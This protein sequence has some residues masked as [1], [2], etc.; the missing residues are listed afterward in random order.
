MYL[1]S[2]WPYQHILRHDKQL[3]RS[4]AT[5][6]L[7][8]T[9]YSA[10]KYKHLLSRH[11]PYRHDMTSNR[12]PATGY[13]GRSWCSGANYK[14]RQ[15][16]AILRH[17]KRSN[18]NPMICE[19]RRSWCSALRCRHRLS[20]QPLC[21]HD[22]MLNRRLTSVSCGRSS[23]SAWSYTHR[24]PSEIFHHGMMLNRRPTILW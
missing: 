6:G 4:Q 21:L 12:K 5:Y 14:H 2:D 16:G 10:L 1:L 23:Y 8:R 9:R 11:L 15:Q 13:S 19:Q 3:N 18:R 7:R 20:R 17:D 22:M 24:R